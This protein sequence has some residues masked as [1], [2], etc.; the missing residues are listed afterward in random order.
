MTAEKMIEQAVLSRLGT[1]VTAVSPIG[2]G[3]SGSVYRVCCNGNPETLA[4]KVSPHPALMRQEFEMLSFLKERTESK[5][6][7]VYFFEETENMAMIAMEYVRG[8]SGNDPRIKR[9]L[10]KKRLARSIIENLLVI[11][12]AHHDRFGPYNRAVY[13]TWQAY[14]REF[15]DEIYGF[16]KSKH[17]DGELEGLVMQAVERSYRNFDCIFSEKIEK[18]TLIH[19]DY[20][21]PNFIIDPRSMELLAAVDPF[22]AMWADPEYELFALTVGYGK[23][24]RLY[25]CYKKRVRVS[26]Y[27]DLKLEI[28]A[29]YSELLWYKKGVPVEHSYLKKRAKRLLKELK[30]HHVC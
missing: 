1:K 13:D 19:G 5:I 3:A 17:A 27:C 15:A 23:K 29:L 4:V 22:N 11:Q 24:L 14:Y 7:S 6:P 28:Y 25:E 18:A 8:V 26:K 12:N 20:W 2:K 10:H 16:S 9:S 21:M 30:K